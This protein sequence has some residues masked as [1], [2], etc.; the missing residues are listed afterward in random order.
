MKTIM[1]VFGTRPEA[2]KMAP[3]IMEMN[4][5]PHQFKTIVCLTG[6]HREMIRSFV[7]Y[8]SISVD[9]D[10]E[11]MREGQ[12][13]AEMTSRLIRKL[14]P[15]V[16][17]KKPD[18]IL[19]QGDTT[20][21]LAGAM[22]GYY[23]DIR[24]AHVEAGLRT[25]NKRAPF[26]EE[27]NRRLIGTIADFHFAPTELAAAA[28]LR[29]NMPAER[30]LVTGNTVI[31]ALLATADQVDGLPEIESLARLAHDDSKMLLITGHRRENFGQGFENICA[32]IKKLALAFP[33]THFVYSVHLN[34]NVQGPVF[35]WLSDLPNVHLIPPQGYMDFVRLLKRSTLVLTDSG[36]IQE[37]APSL[38]KPVLIMRD[39]TERME[40]VSVGAAVLVGT[41]VERIFSVAS[42]LLT[43]EAEYHRMSH[44]GNPFGDGKSSQ[45]I[46]DF[47][48]VASLQS[49]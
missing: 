24:V 14:E 17:E 5:R 12:S 18:V 19:V 3:V 48:D 9:F 47:L 34:P 4:K 40:A 1:F 38:G 43:D 25:N 44:A 26:P 23:N 20:S 37:E 21:A 15:I 49:S 16:R 41:E 46:C 11:V 2:I 28:L 42:R 45:R 31:D 13:L 36:G 22:V 7:E 29:E 6:Q 8:F 39:V 10:L 27:I 33:A 35:S 32:A 30:V